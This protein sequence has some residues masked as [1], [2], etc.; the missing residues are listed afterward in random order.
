MPGTECDIHKDGSLDF[1]DEVL[2]QLDYV[3]ASVHASFT[4]SEAEMTDRIIK[5]ISNPHV[6]ML[7]HL[8]GRLLLTRESYQVNIPAVI[9]A[10]ARDRN[11]HRIQRQPP[12]PRH[13]LALVAAGQGKGREVRHQ[14]GGPLGRGS[15]GSGLRRC[16]ARAR[17]G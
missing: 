12:P 16:N 9:E 5:A 6:T 10:A 3:V 13:G 14:S 15:A 1:S 17:A 2:S 4:V 8:T 11:H 7:G